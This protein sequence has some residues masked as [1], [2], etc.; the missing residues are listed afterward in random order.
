VTL[1]GWEGERRSGVALA[2][3]HR[4]GG[5]S[6][7]GLDSLDREMSTQPTLRRCTTRFIFYAKRRTAY[8]VK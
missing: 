8:L 1:Y 7:Y 5:L 6:T 2:M 3:R 4:L